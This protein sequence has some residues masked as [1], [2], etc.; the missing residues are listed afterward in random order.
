MLAARGQSQ[1]LG[2]VRAKPQ[3]PAGEVLC[4]KQFARLRNAAGNFPVRV[5]GIF[6]VEAVQRGFKYFRVARLKGIEHAGSFA[7]ARRSARRIRSY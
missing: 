2:S 1:F 6:R 3:N 5:A 7:E 4:V